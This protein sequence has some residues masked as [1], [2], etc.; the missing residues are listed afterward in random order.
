MAY[1]L[2]LPL[3]IH[4]T[5]RNDAVQVWVKAQVLSPGV[6]YGYHAHGYSFVF[7]K[8]FQGLPRCIKEGTVH[9]F[10]MFQGELVQ[11]IWQS[12]HHMEIRYWQKLGFS[13]PYPIFPVFAMAFGAVPVTAGVIAD[14]DIAAAIAGIDMSAQ[15]SSPAHPYRR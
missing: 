7:A 11:H 8:S 9:R 13:G 1:I 12:K 4:T 5:A 14:G 15:R 10:G 3:I 2:P 6:Q